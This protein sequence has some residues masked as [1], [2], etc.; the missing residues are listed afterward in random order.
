MFFVV[1][2]CIFFVFLLLPPFLHHPHFLTFI[3]LVMEGHLLGAASYLILPP[4][5]KYVRGTLFVF[6][7]QTLNKSMRSKAKH[8]NC[9]VC[10]VISYHTFP[11]WCVHVPLPGC[12]FQPSQS[13]SCCHVLPG[14]PVRRAVFDGSSLCGLILSALTFCARLSNGLI[15]HNS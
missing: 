1:F 5:C 9:K 6:V 8:V 10:V 11:C 14:N 3:L 2:F 15:I 4:H 12:R 13:L 7:F